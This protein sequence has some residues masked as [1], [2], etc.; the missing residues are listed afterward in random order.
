M[1]NSK[2][3]FLLFF[4]SIFSQCTMLG[5]DNNNNP[6]TRSSSRRETP[7]LGFRLNLSDQITGIPMQHEKFGL[8][9][10]PLSM[11][12]K[13]LKDGYTYANEQSKK[14]FHNYQTRNQKS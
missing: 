10:V 2:T 7:D 12:Q 1:T 9:L 14:S 8:V 4:C 5:M 6:F 11:V 3:F 13:F